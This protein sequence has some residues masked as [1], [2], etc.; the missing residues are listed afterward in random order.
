M[1]VRILIAALLSSCGAPDIPQPDR[2]LHG[3]SY[4]ISPFVDSFEY[5]IGRPIGDVPVNFAEVEPNN[6]G[7]CFVDTEGRA[8]VRVSTTFWTT[9]P[10][11]REALIWHELGHCVL[12]REHDPRLSTGFIDGRLIVVPESVMYPVAKWDH[13]DELRETYAAE[14]ITGGPR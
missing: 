1:T 13:F 11:M 3:I 2:R 7:E 14:L 9:F 5:V 8:E 6:A 12:G 10:E 4:E